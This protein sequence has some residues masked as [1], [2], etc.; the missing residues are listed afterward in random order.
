M[1]P[2]DANALVQLTS[3]PSMRGR[4]R[5]V[6]TLVVVATTPIGGPII[7]GRSSRFGAPSAYAFGGVP[8]MAAVL[9]F[10]R[11]VL[12][13]LGGDGKVVPAAVR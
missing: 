12:C 1:V 13:V 10:G 6:F 5:P 3:H 2:L 8:A 11:T 7:G 9:V 4:A